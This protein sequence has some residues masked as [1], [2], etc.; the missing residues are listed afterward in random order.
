MEVRQ[1]TFGVW[2]DDKEV[3][4]GIFK[5][6]EIGKDNIYVCVDFDVVDGDSV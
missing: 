5:D 3:A 6:K 2:I 4:K 1:E